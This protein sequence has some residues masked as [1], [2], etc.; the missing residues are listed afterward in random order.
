M[1]AEDQP[2]RNLRFTISYDG[3]A[4]S[5]FQI[6]PTSDTIQQRL[7]E[8]VYL[9]TGERVKVASSGR[10]DAGVHAKAQV[11]N[12][13]TQS[14]IPVERWCLALNAR[15]PKD[16]VAHTAEEVHPSFHS[17]K[18][19]KR[20]TYCYTIRSARFPDVFHRNYEYHHPTHLDVEAM[21][22]ALP[23]L[24]GE[25][26]FT[27]FC[28]VRTDK[29]VKVRTLY[30]ARMVLETDE[31]GGEGKVER[32]RLIFTGNGFLYNMVRIIVG[33]LIQIGEG[34]RPSSD[35]QRILE[36]LDRSQAGPTAEAMGLMLWR[37]EY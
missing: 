11:I 4:Y 22:E 30:E 36:A 9:L 1:E 29:E 34:K 35:M 31:L 2:W 17:R 8:A 7:E 23:C 6:Q 20:K 21:R 25:H 37:V 33:T 27:S 28:T 5:G 19:A 15:L 12:F 32:I 13:T 3:T 10:T 16:I 24:L 18:A 26:D 14:K